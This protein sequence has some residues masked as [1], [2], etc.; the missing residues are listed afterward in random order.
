MAKNALSEEQRKAL[1][2]TQLKLLEKIQKSVKETWPGSTV[3]WAKAYKLLVDAHKE[4]K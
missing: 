1:E 4:G 2:D 3:E